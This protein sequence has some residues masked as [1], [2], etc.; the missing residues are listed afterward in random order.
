MGNV[1]DMMNKK[2][3]ECGNNSATRHTAFCSKIDVRDLAKFLSTQL[4]ESLKKQWE[5]ERTFREI[6]EFYVNDPSLAHLP[7]IDRKHK[8]SQNNERKL[9]EANCV[10]Y[11]S[12]ATMFATALSALTNIT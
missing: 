2:C 5:N 11:M 1:V 6:T 3:K 10:Y 7:E 4:R 8:A 9:A 12:R